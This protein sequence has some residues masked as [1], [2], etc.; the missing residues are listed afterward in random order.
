MIPHVRKDLPFVLCL[1]HVSLI[2]LHREQGASYGECVRVH[3]TTPLFFHSVPFHFF[4]TD[5]NLLH[6]LL[7][8]RY[9]VE[10]TQS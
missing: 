4:D 10:S 6:T 2:A 9:G 1:P 3:C 5:A 8:S 7:C